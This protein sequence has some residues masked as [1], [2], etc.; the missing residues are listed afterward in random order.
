MTIEKFVDK[1]RE[2]ENWKVVQ[3][4]AFNSSMTR[5][6]A[7]TIIMNDP[8]CTQTAVNFAVK[9]NSEQK[10]HSI[11]IILQQERYKRNRRLG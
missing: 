11:T 9:I 6:K 3:G 1:S 2:E 4:G 8:T 7:A 10:G 5:E